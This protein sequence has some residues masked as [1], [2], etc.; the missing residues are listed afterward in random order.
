MMLETVRCPECLEKV[1][2]DYQL[3]SKVGLAHFFSLDCPSCHWTNTYCTSRVLKG[4]TGPSNLRN[5]SN[6]YYCCS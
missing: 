4:K 2:V 1:E 6:K 5:K 3:D